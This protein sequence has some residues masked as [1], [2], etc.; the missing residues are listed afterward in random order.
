MEEQEKEKQ[1]KKSFHDIFLRSRRFLEDN[2]SAKRRGLLIVFAIAIIV[3][4]II[5]LETVD[6]GISDKG[7]VDPIFASKEKVAEY[8]E[9]V[10]NYNNVADD[11]KKVRE[12]AS[13]KNAGILS[14]I[15]ELKVYLDENAENRVLEDVIS[16][17]AEQ[18]LKETVELKDALILA[19]SAFNQKISRYNEAVKN[20]N[21]VI[22][23]YKKIRKITSL[24][25][26]ADL[27]EA[28]EPKEYLEKN[29]GISDFVQN[30]I[31]QDIIIQETEPII[32][33]TEELLYTLILAQQI[34]KP[35]EYWVI[36]RLK[37]IDCITDVEAVTKD[38]DPN[39]FLNVD[40]GYISCIYFL[41]EGI[42]QNS[43]K[44]TSVID[45]GTD[46]GG[47][48]EV[49]KTVADALN[50]CEY[51]SQFDDTLL[52]SG[53]YAILGTTVIRTSYLLTNEQ[54]IE[55]TNKIITAFTALR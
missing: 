18:I 39:Q 4:A 24:E 10:K 2:T 34:T 26:I 20:Y 40:G 23:E 33:E 35:D 15:G 7:Q 38:H 53:S 8:N 25:N 13:L 50:R 51:L 22:D 37:T 43:I 54:Q 46:A 42:D 49:Y 36:D 52:Y 44:G 19:H 9:V 11:Y 12:I 6:H 47:A 17:D 48:I 29:A 21:A 3:L 45:K 30:G 32:Q 28:K 16:E 1:L 14:D 41:V 55:L 31:S 27:P 5:A